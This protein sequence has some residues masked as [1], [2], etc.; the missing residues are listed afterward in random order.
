MSENRLS[1]ELTEIEAALGS[2]TPRASG[3]ERDQVMFL[4]GQAS[5][6]RTDTLRRRR[7]AIWLWPCATAASLLVAA[8]FGTLWAAGTH[9]T[10]VPQIV[11][12]PVERPA[13]TLQTAVSKPS[14]LA[15]GDW[16]LAPQTRRKMGRIAPPPNPA[17]ERHA[18]RSS[19]RHDRAEAAQSLT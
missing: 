9:S 3:V 16:Q 19:D 1:G 4:A 17:P 11:Y 13:T 18:P 6:G 2:L 15:F 7:I 5:A 10:S 8:A 12:V 14:S